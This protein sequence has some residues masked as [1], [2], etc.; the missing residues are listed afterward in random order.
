M[1]EKKE[2][3][4]TRGGE[5]RCSN[6]HSLANS[7]GHRTGWQVVPNC[8]KQ[9]ASARPNLE[10]QVPPR[11]RPIVPRLTA[12]DSI[13]TMAAPTA[14]VGRTER[15]TDTAFAPDPRAKVPTPVAGTMDSRSPVST[16]GLGEITIWFL[17]VP[18]SFSGTTPNAIVALRPRARIFSL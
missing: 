1:D 10:R 16:P 15:R 7:P 2:V 12:A 4:E 17:S 5:K 13:S 18:Y 8:L 6:S 9:V 3:E 11:R 14:A